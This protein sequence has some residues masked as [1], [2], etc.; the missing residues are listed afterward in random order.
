MLF[1]CQ[2]NQTCIITKIVRKKFYIYFLN[3][4]FLEFSDKIIIV[5]VATCNII[6]KTNSSKT[7]LMKSSGR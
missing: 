4:D 1:C 5:S 7:C 2:N 6:S 3:F